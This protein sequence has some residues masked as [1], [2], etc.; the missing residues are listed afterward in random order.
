[1]GGYFV[2][3]RFAGVKGQT[4][5]TFFLRVLQCVVAHYSEKLDG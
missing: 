4:Q 2:H 3:T 5:I 1:M